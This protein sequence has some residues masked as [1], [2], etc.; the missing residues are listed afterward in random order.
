MKGRKEL[1]LSAGLVLLLVVAAYYFFS[2]RDD[3]TG[4]PGVLAADTKFEPL[5]IREPELRMDLLEKVRKLEYTGSH[6][7]IFLVTPA[8]PAKAVVQAVE[9]ARAF[10]GPKVPPP[11]PPLQVPAE[12]FGFASEPH[13]RHR[14]AFFAS[15]D[16]VLVVG[17]GET[18]LGRFRL[19]RVNNDFADV[20]EIGTGRH[21]T[22]QL[23]PPP[24][25]G[26]NR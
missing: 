18:F 11:P 3:G 17:E 2:S 22:L 26:G 21:T 5:Q 12:F 20:E 10:I 23:V 19:D 24:E 14:V 1:Y 9:P 7:N 13:G 15:G 6:R 4:L 25:Q 16:D 8:A